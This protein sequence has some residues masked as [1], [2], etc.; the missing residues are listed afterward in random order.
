MQGIWNRHLGLGARGR[1]HFFMQ[2]YIRL[3]FVVSYDSDC[4]AGE[5]FGVWG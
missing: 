2:W 4:L 5:A 3:L 1:C